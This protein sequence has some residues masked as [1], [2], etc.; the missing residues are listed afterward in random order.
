MTYMI[1]LWRGSLLSIESEGENILQEKVMFISWVIFTSLYLGHLNVVSLVQRGKIPV[2]LA[3]LHRQTCHIEMEA[4][5]QKAP[6]QSQSPPP[7]LTHRINRKSSPLLCL[8]TSVPDN[9]CHALWQKHDRVTCR[10]LVLKNWPCRHQRLSEQPK[11]DGWIVL[12]MVHSGSSHEIDIRGQFARPWISFYLNVP[13]TAFVG[14]LHYTMGTTRPQGG[15][16]KTMN[17]GT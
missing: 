4:A 3:H 5:E 15:F 16:T 2:I 1:G 13:R 10:V 8:T 7:P 12:F 6:F 9:S 17:G 14:F 11:V